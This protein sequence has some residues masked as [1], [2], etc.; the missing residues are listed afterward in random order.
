MM[1]NILTYTVPH[2]KT[3]DVLC[4]LKALGYDDVTVWMMPMAYQKSF[5]PLINHRNNNLLYSPPFFRKKARASYHGKEA[6]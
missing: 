4:L 2:R 6:A 3:Y 1:V 5:T